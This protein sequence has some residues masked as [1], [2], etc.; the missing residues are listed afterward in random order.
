MHAVWHSDQIWEVLE[1]EVD[2]LS[3]LA[4]HI[5]ATNFFRICSNGSNMR[6]KPQAIG[7]SVDCVQ[8]ST[9][10][11]PHTHTKDMH[12]DTCRCV[13]KTVELHC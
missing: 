6:E 12:K 10:L 5:L 3:Y 11:T 9:Q 2:N 13:V 4:S 8:Y 7:G 1:V